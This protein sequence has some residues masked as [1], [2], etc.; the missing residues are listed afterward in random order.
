VSQEFYWSGANAIR[1]T[2][3]VLSLPARAGGGTA[4]AS[5][6]HLSAGVSHNWLRGRVFPYVVGTLGVYRV[7]EGKRDATEVGLYGAAGME[8]RLGESVTFRL[9]MGLHGLT[10][11]PPD[12]I[13]AG[14]V[15]V[16]FYY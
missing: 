10:G 4:R 14:S 1:G 11:P 2:L 5:I 8:V 12:A 7:D 6:Y 3:G 9:E 13:L 15:G 16:S